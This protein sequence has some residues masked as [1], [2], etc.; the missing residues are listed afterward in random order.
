MVTFLRI[1]NV[2]TQ[3]ICK[4]FQWK[5]ITVDFELKSLLNSDP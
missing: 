4:I 2:N 5:T 1:S 3:L